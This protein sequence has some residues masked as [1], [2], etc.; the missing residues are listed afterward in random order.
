MYSPKYIYSR[1]SYYVLVVLPVCQIMFISSSLYFSKVRK[2]GSY[3]PSC[4]TVLNFN[5][6]FKLY[7]LFVTSCTSVFCFKNT[8]V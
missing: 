3:V 1:G 6:I 8:Y 5:V 7:I 4:S 2:D